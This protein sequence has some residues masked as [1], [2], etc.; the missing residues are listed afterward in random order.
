[1][2]TS[3]WVLRLVLQARMLGWKRWQR[4]KK[5]DWPPVGPPL[6]VGVKIESVSQIRV[7]VQRTGQAS[8]IQKGCNRQRAAR[9]VLGFGIDRSWSGRGGQ[10]RTV[11]TERQA[12]WTRINY[13]PLARVACQARRV[14]FGKREMEWS[15]VTQEPSSAELQAR[16][17]MRGRRGKVSRGLSEDP[18]VRPATQRHCR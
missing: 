16:V 15:H 3:A 9:L 6:V 13:G 18:A 5:R 1:L 2:Y 7:F 8:L 4:A 17:K 12:Q 14:P 11:N 10:A